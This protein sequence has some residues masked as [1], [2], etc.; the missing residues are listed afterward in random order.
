MIRSFNLKT[1]GEITTRERV[2]RG[3]KVG[4]YQTRYNY[5]N[6]CQNRCQNKAPP[7]YLGPP[8]YSYSLPPAPFESRECP[9]QYPEATQEPD[10]E[11]FEY[12]T[13]EEPKE[14]PKEE[15]PTEPTQEPA[16][17]PT[18]ENE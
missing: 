7:Q 3:K 16:D 2:T 13:L 4:V 9:Q 6:R 10:D 17:E 15:E 18:V 14:D 12:P 8:E 5:Q 1:R 11:P